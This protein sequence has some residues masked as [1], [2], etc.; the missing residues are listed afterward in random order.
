MGAENSWTIVGGGEVS[1]ERIVP[2][3]HSLGVPKSQITIADIDRTV[4][5]WWAGCHYPVMDLSQHSFE[6]LLDSFGGTVL[7]ATPTA[8]HLAYTQTVH[9]AGHSFVVE[10]PLTL[11]VDEFVNIRTHPH[12][13]DNGFALSY[14][15][16]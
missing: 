7:I 10:K 3:L 2:A 4:L 11:D 15:S 5:T 12:M 9:E 1:S 8:H 16:L 14:Y 6:H 13:F